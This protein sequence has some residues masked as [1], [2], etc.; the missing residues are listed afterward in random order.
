MLC[1]LEKIFRIWED[2]H[3][4]LII[5]FLRI[6]YELSP[7]L[8]GT[9]KIFWY[10]E[11]SPP[12]PPLPFDLCWRVLLFFSFC[13][14]SFEW[15]SYHIRVVLYHIEGV[16]SWTFIY[17][18][19]CNRTVWTELFYPGGSVVDSLPYTILIVS[20]NVLKR[21]T[22]SWLNPVISLMINSLLKGTFLNWKTTINDLVFWVNNY[23]VIFIMNNLL[24]LMIFLRISSRD[25]YNN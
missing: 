14:F 15:Y 9:R 12:P 17:V 21:S 11:F 16:S 3:T 20:R 19:V 7:S 6:C 25:I 4:H 10:F 23:F 8:F 13:P 5:K 2:T 24:N 1:E 22:W 18:A